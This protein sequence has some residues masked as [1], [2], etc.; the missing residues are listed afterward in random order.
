MTK[1]SLAAFSPL[2]LPANKPNVYSFPTRQKVQQE[3]ETFE[4]FEAQHLKF[5]LQKETNTQHRLTVTRG[6]WS[7][8]EHPFRVWN[9]QGESRFIR[10]P[11]YKIFARFPS[12]EAGVSY[13]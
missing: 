2:A 7:C 4:T 6:P 13:V 5:G 8:P 11:E 12:I 1:L 10:F 3:P 9:K